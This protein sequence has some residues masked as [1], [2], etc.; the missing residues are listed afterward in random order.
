MLIEDVLARLCGEQRLMEVEHF[1]WRSERKRRV[2]ATQDINRFLTL[3]ARDS[4]TN[5]DRRRLQALFDRFISGEFISIGL[6]PPI[7]ATDIKRL[8]PASAEVWEFKVGRRRSQLRVFGRFA[9]LN[10]FVALTGPVDR[11]Q[12]HYER[13][14]LRCREEW[15]RLFDDE[16][17]LHGKNEYGYVS[18][19]GLSLRDS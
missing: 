18:P 13:E 2:Y 3:E 10:T 19:N 6:E 4:G 17:P 9:A 16:P 7:M 8:S 5:R 14:I 15:R 11:T 12:L 1:D